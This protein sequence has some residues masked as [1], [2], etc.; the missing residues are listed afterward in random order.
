MAGRRWVRGDV[1][2]E[3]Q[4]WRDV[5][6]C[7]IAS[8]VV[9]DTPEHLV[10]FIATGAELDYT[11][12]PYPAPSGRHPRWPSRAWT[13]HGTLVVTRP[14]DL[15]SVMHFW[16][17]PDRAFKWWYVN[18]QEPLR[19]TPAGLDGQ[20]LELDIVVSPDGSWEI[21]DDDVLEQRVD[22]GRYRRD[23]V[24]AIREVG[25]RIVSDVLEPGTPWWGDRWVDWEPHPAWIEPRLPAGWA[26]PPGTACPPWFTP[27]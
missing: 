17:G 25:A 6:S 4:V 27:A 24:A 15:Y 26:D 2:A 8:I 23:E 11:D 19:R 22:E 13:G 16:D 20:D 1:I 14:G 21:K 7:A 18:I 9:E 10:T 12:E 3:R 5:V